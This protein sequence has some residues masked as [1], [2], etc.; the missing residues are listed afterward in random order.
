M[1]I[2]ASE[3]RLILEDALAWLVVMAMFIYGLGKWMQ[4]PDTS[5]HTTLV[6]DM[7]GMQLMWAFYGYSKPFAIF[8]GALEISGGILLLYRPWRLLGA[9][10]LSTVLVN[11]IIQDIVFDVNQGALKAALIY[12]TALLV[13]C[14]LHRARF[15]A[16][17]KALTLPRSYQGLPKRSLLIR[18]ALAFLLFALLRGAEYFLSH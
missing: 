5:I 10:F 16:A 13:I 9:L 8:L 14:W 12:Q 7:S 2:T 11:I 1:P 15:I 4:F 3:R 6:S 18:L 17:L